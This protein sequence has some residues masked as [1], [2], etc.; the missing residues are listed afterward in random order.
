M[1]VTAPERDPATLSPAEA[2]V[3]DVGNIGWRQWLRERPADVV[4]QLPYRWTSMWARPAQRLPEGDW[5]LWMIR[6]GRGFGKTRTGAEAVRQLVNDGRASEVTILGPKA[7]DARD[8]MVEGPSGILRVHPPAVRPKYEP[9]KRLITWPNGAVGHV[10]SAED[11]DDVRG[12]NSDLV[13][14]DEPASWKS[15]EEPWDNAMLG[16]RIGTPHAILTGTPRPLPWLRKLEEQPRTIVTTGNTY[17]NVANL[18][19]VFVRLILERYEGTRLGAQELHA[20][21]LEDVEGALWT[22]LS[23]E[24]SR[25]QRWN[26]DEPWRA[27]SVAWGPMAA[28]FGRL[29]QAFTDRRRWITAVGVDP[30]GETAEC[31]IVVATAPDSGYAARDHAVVLDDRS[32]AGAPEV[33]GAAVAQAAHDYQADVVVVEANQGGDMVRSTIHAHDPNLNIVKVRAKDSKSDRAEPISVLY[34]KGWVHH[35]GNL[36]T[37]ES[38]MTT[39][40]PNES[41]SPDR[42]DA[43]VHV[44]THLLRPVAI[45]SASL[46]DQ[47][48]LAST[49]L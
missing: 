43:A 5:D 16:N 1:T 2:F 8:V 10:R 39:W 15:G 27:L 25:F 36:P 11:P 32:L 29:A 42:I 19:P 6:A 38:Q 34:A 41:K 28:R 4:K 35:L 24:S 46:P 22:M 45:G 33:W 20:A 44:L 30:P 7:A 12:L 49:T 47:S 48:S 21:Y 17:E 37:L 26:R 13:W 14:G 40:V 23:I 3:R 18:A 31:G 9:S